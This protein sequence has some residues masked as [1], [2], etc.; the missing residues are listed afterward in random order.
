MGFGVLPPTKRSVRG[1]ADLRRGRALARGM[2]APTPLRL[3]GEIPAIA[4]AGGEPDVPNAE[5][6]VLRRMSKEVEAWWSL[7]AT[8]GLA[9]SETK[10][11]TSN[12]KKNRIAL[13]IGSRRR[14]GARV[15]AVVWSTADISEIKGIIPSCESHQKL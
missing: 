14:M 13:E 4:H 15:L 8:F 11:V 10:K 1:G 3:G 6:R 7:A 12:W 5:G 2:R 9:L